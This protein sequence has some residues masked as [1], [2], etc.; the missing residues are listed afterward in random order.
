MF[1]KKAFYFIVCAKIV[2]VLALLIDS[3]CKREE[4]DKDTFSMAFMTDIHIEYG[5]NAVAG[6]EK[7]LDTVNQLKP[8]FI[9]TGGDLVADALGQ[10]YG[11]TDSLYNLYKEVIKKAEATVYNTMGNHEI[12]GIYSRS[13]LI[14]PIRN[15]VRRCLKKE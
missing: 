7:A 5:K 8:D 9:L 10:S 4:K 12:Y 1:K 15:M 11:R 2:L 3:G 14:L 13:G 6:F